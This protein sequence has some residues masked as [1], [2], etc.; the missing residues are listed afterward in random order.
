[1]PSHND[2]SSPDRPDRFLYGNSHSKYQAT[3][4]DEVDETYAQETNAT[5]PRSHDSRDNATSARLETTLDPSSFSTHAIHSSS[6]SDIYSS[7]NVPSQTLRHGVR[8]SDRGPPLV[9]ATTSRCTKPGLGEERSENALSTRIHED[10][11]RQLVRQWGQLFDEYC[12]PTDRM[13]QVTRI[14]AKQLVS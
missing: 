10:H 13:R 3:V 14:I 8:F 11:Q 6:E 2:S 7:A 4:E 1:M 5:S 12:Q 9:R